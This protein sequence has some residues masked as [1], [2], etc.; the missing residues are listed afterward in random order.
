MKNM[1]HKKIIKISVM[2]LRSFISLIRKMFES[3]MYSIS[4][5]SGTVVFQPEAFS[6]N[7]IID[8]KKR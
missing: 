2:I 4:T 3:E 8:D 6:E 7:D 1:C 5:E